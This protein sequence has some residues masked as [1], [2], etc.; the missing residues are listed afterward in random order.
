MGNWKKIA[1][2]SLLFFCGGCQ[3]E[4]AENNMYGIITDSRQESN[5]KRAERIKEELGKMKDLS[6][7]AVLVEGHTA[8]IGLRLE[9]A[10]KKQIKAM[11]TEAEQR[12]KTADAE[13]QNVSVTIEE[14]LVRRI[15]KE[16]RK[17]QA[18][19]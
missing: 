14:S 3:M 15:E 5:G 2:F 9:K 1:I 8:I 12:A 17:Q 13:I 4:G 10:D 11:M 18:E 6:G 19:G 7:S 16:E